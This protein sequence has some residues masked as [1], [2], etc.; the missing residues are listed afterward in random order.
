ME[1]VGVETMTPSARKRATFLA[2]EFHGEVA[3]ACDVAFGDDDLIQRFEGLDGR[4][5]AQDFS[6][7]HVARIKGMAVVAP[8]FERGIEI[9]EA[10]LGEEAEKAQ[11]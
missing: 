11:G 8:A 10:H 1:P 9:G 4:A 7:E 3:H 2:I 5:V 6:V